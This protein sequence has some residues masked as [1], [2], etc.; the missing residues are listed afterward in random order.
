MSSAALAAMYFSPLKSSIVFF[1]SLLEAPFCL[2]A[3][4]GLPFPSYSHTAEVS[5]F[6]LPMTHRWDTAPA[7]QTRSATQQQ[8]CRLSQPAGGN[9]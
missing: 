8:P 2:H 9:G 6:T 7:T 3:L 5:S 4:F 1:F